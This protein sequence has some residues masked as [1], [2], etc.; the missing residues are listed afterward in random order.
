MAETPKLD[1]AAARR[2]VDAAL[3]EDLKAPGD[4]TSEAVIGENVRAAGRLVAKEAGVVCGLDVARLVFEAVDEAIELRAETA[5]GKRV[6]AGETFATVDG[7][8]RGILAA[9][10]TALNI[11]QHMSG[12]ATLTAEAVARAAGTRA[13]IFD[14]RKTL[15][16]LRDLEKYA[17]AVGGGVNHRMGLFDAVLLKDNHISV[18]GGIAEAVAAVRARQGREAP[19]EVETETLDEVREALDAGADVIML[20]NM[21][22]DTIR[23]AVSIVGGRATVEASG[24]IRPKDV[25]EIAATGVDRISIGELTDAPRLDISLEIGT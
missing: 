21:G 13:R 2:V 12:I 23:E 14:T 7:P 11:M 24:G 18:A 22:V 9:E 25:E 4:I 3:A 19:I 8:A 1:L 16:G 20:D 6:V 17:V 15:P 5:D 10:R